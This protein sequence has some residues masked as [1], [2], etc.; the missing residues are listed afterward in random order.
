MV[1]ITLDTQCSLNIRQRAATIIVQWSVL[2]DVMLL[3]DIIHII[4]FLPKY[5]FNDIQKYL[6]EKGQSFFLPYDRYNYFIV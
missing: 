6:T 4:V 3:E 5:K 2:Y 1:S